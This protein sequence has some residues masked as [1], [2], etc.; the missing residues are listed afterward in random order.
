M[1]DKKEVLKYQNYQGCQ[2]DEK[3]D[4]FIKNF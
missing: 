2:S 1:I 3:I 4:S